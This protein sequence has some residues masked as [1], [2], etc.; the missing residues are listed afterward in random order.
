MMME[1]RFY[2]MYIVSLYMLGT[3]ENE[4]SQKKLGVYFLP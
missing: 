2:D 4:S 1:S 3:I